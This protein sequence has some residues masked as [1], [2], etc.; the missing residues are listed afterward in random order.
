[1]QTNHT[2]NVPL[3]SADNFFPQ[4]CL[5]LKPLHCNKATGAQQKACPAEQLHHTHGVMRCVHWRKVVQKTQI[6]HSIQA[7]QN[8]TI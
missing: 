7:K 2:P 8:L 1:M 3:T 4:Q 5:Q 6:F